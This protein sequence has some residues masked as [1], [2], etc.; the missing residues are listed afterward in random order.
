MLPMLIF[1]GIKS[2]SSKVAKIGSCYRFLGNNISNN[3]AE[4]HGVIYGLGLASAN[5][6][7][8]V[9][10]LTDSSLVV[11]QMNGKWKVVHPDMIALNARVKE[12]VKYFSSVKFEHIPR[13]KN[14][15]ADF[16]SNLAMD[17]G[18]RK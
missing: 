4:Y 3:V 12:Y 7:K 14:K 9:K 16:L 18:N 5:Q 10:V 17:L 6:A 2:L 1:D 11:N 8:R 15:E 13:E